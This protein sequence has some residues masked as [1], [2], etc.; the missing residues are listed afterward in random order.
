VN[1][2]PVAPAKSSGQT[3][4]T[5]KP[6]TLNAAFWRPFADLPPKDFDAGG[7]AAHHHGFCVEASLVQGG[8]PKLEFAED[9]GLAVRGA[10]S[11]IIKLTHVGHAAE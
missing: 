1:G 7:S 3:S 2:R 9:V 10:G 5:T 4:G 11:V 8:A 6:K